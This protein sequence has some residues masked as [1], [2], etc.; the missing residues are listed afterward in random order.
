MATKYIDI[1]PL[2][3]LNETLKAN[4]SEDLKRVNELIDRIAKT[5]KR[6]A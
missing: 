4:L 1:T 2:R 5:R 6:M 3:K